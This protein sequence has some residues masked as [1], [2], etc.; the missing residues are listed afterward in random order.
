VQQAQERP[1]PTKNKNSIASECLFLEH[2]HVLLS[3]FDTSIPQIDNEFLSWH[4]SLRTVNKVQLLCFWT[5]T[6]ALFSLKTHNVP[7]TAVSGVLL[8]AL[9]HSLHNTVTCLHT[10]KPQG[11]S[12]LAMWVNGS[13]ATAIQ[14]NTCRVHVARVAI[15]FVA[16]AT[17]AIYRCFRFTLHL[18]AT[19]FLLLLMFLPSDAPTACP[20]RKQGHPASGFRC[21]H[22]VNGAGSFFKRSQLV[23]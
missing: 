10:E 19:A 16:M 6:I 20:V 2:W 11:R 22:D 23:D 1:N 3:Y 17:P 21:F 12:S 8:G 4:T 14:W 18:L 9:Q 7:Q 5:L 13:S 15:T